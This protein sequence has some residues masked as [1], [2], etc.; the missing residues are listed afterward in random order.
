MH[1][2]VEA[3]PK[4]LDLRLDFVTYKINALQ[5]SHK[6]LWKDTKA[7]KWSLVQKIGVLS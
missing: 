5:R 1:A 6:G 7:S 3:D 4:T 2:S